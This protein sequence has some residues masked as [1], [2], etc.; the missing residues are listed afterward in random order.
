MN[1]YVHEKISE[2]ERELEKELL[3][4]RPRPERPRRRPS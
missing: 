2:L 1:F 3:T 4:H